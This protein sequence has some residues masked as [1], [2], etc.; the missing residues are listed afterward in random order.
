MKFKYYI[1]L[2]ATLYIKPLIAQE[3]YYTDTLK[4]FI[5]IQTLIAENRIDDF[6]KFTDDYSYVAG[7]EN[8]YVKL[9]TDLNS[10]LKDFTILVAITKSQNLICSISRSDD[11]TNGK[12]TKLEL[13]KIWQELFK[14]M[15]HGLH[16]RMYETFR[17]FCENKDG[18][19]RD[20]IDWEDLGRYK[21]KMGDKDNKETWETY[22]AS[23]FNTSFSN[24]RAWNYT[25]WGPG[26]VDYL[27]ISFPKHE[28]KDWKDEVKPLFFISATKMSFEN[29][30]SNNKE[31]FNIPFFMSL[32]NF[33][34]RIWADN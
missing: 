26:K 16:Y 13:F 21:H 20:K 9:I 28:D 18:K 23:N 30:P 25:F 14:S 34:D 24:E 29:D 11:I 4:E 5:A 27:M 17:E 1:C 31:P 22:S 6:S 33:N 12:I 10:P 2:I 8:V 3:Q 32:K 15:K 19:N 7:K